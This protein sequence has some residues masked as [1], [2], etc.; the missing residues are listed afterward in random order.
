M[1]YF[2]L[3]FI[4]ANRPYFDINRL[5][6]MSEYL[7]KVQLKNRLEQKGLLRRF[8]TNCYGKQTTLEDIRS[9]KS[10]KFKKFKEKGIKK[11]TLEYQKHF[12]RYVPDEEK[13]IIVKL[14][15]IVKI[16][17]IKIKNKK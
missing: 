17:K 16:I 5:L 1:L 13:I 7:F 12:L 6:C 3:I 8:S 9:Y 15:I 2:Y 14:K 4:Y 10:K 11:G